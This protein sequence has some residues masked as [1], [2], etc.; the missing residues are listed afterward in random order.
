MD[1]AVRAAITVFLVGVVSLALVLVVTHAGGDAQATATSAVWVENVCGG[2]NEAVVAI[3]EAG[4]PHPL[5]CGR[6]AEGQRSIVATAPLAVLV[7]RPVY[8][9]D[10]FMPTGGKV[11]LNPKGLVPAPDVEVWTLEHCP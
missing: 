3:D 6:S 2:T 1:R 9:L 11:S 4:D 10:C 8:H 5:A 7:K